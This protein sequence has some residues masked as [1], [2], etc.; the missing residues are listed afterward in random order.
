MVLHTYDERDLVSRLSRLDRQS[1]TAFAAACAQRLLPMFDRYSQSA[2]APKLGSRLAE[3]VNY[4]WEAAAAGRAPVTMDALQTDAEAMVPSDQD[5]WTREMGYGQNS[6]AAAAYAIRTWLTDDPQEAA[7]AA[8]QVYELAD[9]VVLQS[10]PDLDLNS[11][12][13]AAWVLASDLVQHE[14]GGLADALA[15]VEGESTDW[16]KLRT[17]AEAGGQ[18]LANAAP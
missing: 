14:L 10:K 3:I 8:R 5:G 16:R 9:Y 12:H 11:S 1:K 4:A 18:I 15:E 6:A 7:W 17:D 13:T 2:G